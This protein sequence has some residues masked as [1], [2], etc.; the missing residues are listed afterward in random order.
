VS[1]LA[2]SHFSRIS[3]QPSN[4]IPPDP[5]NQERPIFTPSNIQIR[6]DDVENAHIGV[7]FQVPG[8]NSKVF[9]H[10]LLMQRVFGNYDRSYQ[11]EFED[12]SAH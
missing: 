7:F 1:T 2:N 4:G 10:L 3:K 12:H 9:P 8:F 5:V 6:D 11:D